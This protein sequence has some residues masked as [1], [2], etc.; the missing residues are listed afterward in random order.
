MTLP[1][2]NLD[3]LRFQKD[4][5]DEARR[6]I[7]RYCPEWTEYNLSD[8][9]ITLIE[10]FAWMTEMILYRVNQVP[11]K[12]YLRFLDL[13]GVQRQPASAARADLTFWLSVPLPI[14]PEN[15]DPVVV[16]QGI[17]VAS[18]GEGGEIIFTTS[19]KLSILPPRLTQLRRAQDFNKNYYP[20]LGIET[21][22]AFNQPRPQVGDTFYVGFDENRDLRGHI[23]RL[24]FKCRPTEAVGVRREDPPW[25]WECSLGNGEWKEIPLSNRLGEKDTTGGLNNAE[26]SLT[27][28]LPLEMNPDQVQGRSAFWLRCKLEP[29][30][31]AQGMYAESPQIIGLQ[32]FTLGGSVPA[33]HAVVV[34]E[35]RLGLS[36]GEPGQ[37]FRLSNAPILA[38]QDD[39]T[40]E[41]E[42]I[43]HGDVVFVPWTPVNDFS[44]S[45]RFD[46]HFMV[47]TSSG[48]ITLGP[49]I[50]QPDG[51]VVQYGRIP[52]SQRVVRF[53]RYRYGGGVKGNVPAD[54]LKTLKTS[55]A[56][57]ARV[58]N[59]Y[60]ASG[61]RD[62]ESLDEVKARARRELQ[63]QMRAVT[64]E[65]YEQLARSATRNVAR[66]K[67]NPPVRVEAGTPPSGVVELL[68]VPA[69]A[70]ALRVG[71]LTKLR[72]DPGLKQMILDYLDRYRLLTTTMH[73]REP[74]Y[75]GVK[76]KARVVV[77]EYS[78]PDVVRSRIIQKINA[79][80]SPLP[81]SS[82]PEDQDELMGAGWEGW[83]FGR[84]LFVAEIL[85]LIQRVP[86]VKYVLD[87]QLLSRPVVPAEEVPPEDQE[88]LP[89]EKPFTVF[90]GKVLQVPADSLVCSIDPEISLVDI[91]ALY[92]AEQ[93]SGA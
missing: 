44:R 90:D 16:P 30:R 19:R 65:D 14:T 86:G 36:N 8:P 38:L 32:A 88:L 84:D 79:Y 67:C 34:S 70:D 63:A 77:S 66:V 10:L 41:I 43:R 3:D 18:P 17:Q 40:L 75:L 93:S 89:P 24:A 45:T 35:E 73:I 83:Q 72:V 6:R 50:R 2:P 9:G 49:G 85:S 46:R 74:R 21:F 56:Y 29:R 42:E 47:D 78:Q 76:V 87:V 69:V 48:E 55:L 71:D 80:L 25:V 57:I 15:D 54:S 82:N 64:S 23:L 33:T 59:L 5:V 28:Y 1:A 52:E 7:T 91:S 68:I 92:D 27:L 39:E 61:G 37:R 22:P 58:T 53:K 26:G 31:A 11:E 51:T 60:R 81:V 4:I 13:L 12:N 62:E 20:R